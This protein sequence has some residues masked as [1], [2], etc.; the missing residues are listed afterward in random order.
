MFNT[1]QSRRQL[2]AVLCGVL[3]SA[4]LTADTL[5]IT[6]PTK[7]PYGLSAMSAKPQHDNLLLYSTQVSDSKRTAVVNQ[8]VVTVGSRVAGA[9]VVTIEQ[10]RVTLRRGAETIVLR[11]IKTPVRRDSKDSL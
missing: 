7:P 3:F 2:T 10:G 4:G 6:D 9:V 5:P 11:L 1:S 8:R